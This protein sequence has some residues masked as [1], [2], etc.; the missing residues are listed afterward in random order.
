MMSVI[1]GYGDHIN[2]CI[3]DFIFRLI[4][5]LKHDIRKGNEVNCYDLRHTQSGPPRGGGR[6]GQIAPGP[7]IN[8]APKLEVGA[9]NLSILLKLNKAHQNRAQYKA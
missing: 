8:R 6:G 1:S 9:P 2:R 4:L 5:R 3:F 7:Q